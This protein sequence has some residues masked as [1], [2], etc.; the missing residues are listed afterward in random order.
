MITIRD[1]LDFGPKIILMFKT[2]FAATIILVL[3]V[4]TLTFFGTK[5][6]FI[7]H[8]EVS[9]A[10]SIDPKNYKPIAV[11][12]K[13]FINENVPLDGYAYSN[14]TFTNVTF[15]YNGITPVQFTNN[16]V[17]GFVLKSDNQGI[18]NTLETLYAFGMINKNVEVTIPP[19][20]KIDPP[21]KE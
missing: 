13:D 10:S 19:G 15:T 2:Q 17:K 5:Y 16:S 7:H 3:T 18:N 21:T 9:S 20:T 12:G 14:N 6:Y 4:G 8:V 11:I 1:I